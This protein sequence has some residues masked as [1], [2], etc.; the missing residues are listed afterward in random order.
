MTDYIFGLNG[1][2]N[3]NKYKK[4]IEKDVNDIF[5]KENYISI[6]KLK[7]TSLWT[8]MT[9]NGI[10]Q[11]LMDKINNIFALDGDGDTVSKEELNLLL[12]LADGDSNNKFD[13]KYQIDKNSTLQTISQSEIEDFYNITKD[14]ENITKQDVKIGSFRRSKNSDSIGT[15]VVKVGEK[16]ITVNIDKSVTEGGNFLRE[17]Y[18]NKKYPNTEYLESLVND[19]FENLDEQALKELT[20]NIDTIEL[21]G[22]EAINA[23][24]KE[25]FGEKLNVDGY[26]DSE[27]GNKIVLSVEK[28]DVYE[29]PETRI[30]KYRAFS[31]GEISKT[32]RHEV[33]HSLD[34]Y[35]DEED[36]SINS[37]SNNQFEDK[38]NELKEKL[39]KLGISGKD[40]YCL[41]SVGEYLAEYNSSS[42][43]N[44]EDS[45][46]NKLISELQARL[47]NSSDENERAQ[48]QDILN[49]I[50]NMNSDCNDVLKYTRNA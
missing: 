14:Q 18:G 32:L 44:G 15:M 5:K 41:V 43:E 1:T 17:A 40:F 50:N 24:T 39:E 26:I 2:F 37:W 49:D 36:G 6:D 42:Y 20:K 13:N 23:D 38:M 4:N 12:R 27:P 47:E 28:I 31:A 34:F 11:N 45:S 16:E 9:K 25:Y 10:D 7:S 19:I 3:N 35:K 30:I 22:K 21:K 29:T 48:I 33:T 8:K 46:Y